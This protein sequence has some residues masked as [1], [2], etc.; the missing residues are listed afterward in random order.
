MTGLALLPLAAVAGPAAAGDTVEVVS[1]HGQSAAHATASTANAAGRNKARTGRHGHAKVFPTQQAAKAQAQAQ[2]PEAA[3]AAAGYG[4]LIYSGGVSGVGVTTGAPQV[5]LVFWGSQWGQSS[6]TST[7]A[8]QLSGDPKGVAPRL[9]ALMKGIGTNNETWSGVMTQ[10]CEGVAPGST[11]CPSTATHVGYPTGGTLAG[12]WADPSAAAPQQ[13]TAQQIA[14]EG[15]RAAGHFGRTTPGSNRNVQY[16]VVSPTGT[17]PDGF[18]TGS[19]TSNFCAWHDWN[20]DTAM[21]GGA[22]ASPY[23]D[24]AFTNLPYVS[25]AGATCGAGYVNGAAGPLDGFL[26]VAGHEYAETIT[27][28]NPAG[29]W[30]DAVGS[31]NA[32]KCS[33]IGVGGSTGAQNLTFATGSFPMQ[34]TWSNTANA[35]EISH[36]VVRTTA[37][38]VV[39][40]T[41]PGTQTGAVRA[42]KTLQL[43]ATDSTGAALSYTAQGLPAGLAISTTGLVSGTPTT[44]GS[45]AVSVTARDSAGGS[46]SASF[47]WTISPASTCRAPGQKLGNTG[48]ETGVA[49]PWRTTAGVVDKSAAQGPH[50]GLWKA[51]LDGY[52]TSHT[53]TL[54]QTVTLPLGCASYTFSYWMHV[55]S[56]DT[57]TLAHDAMTVRAGTTI[58]ATYSNL[59][60]STGYIQRSFGLSRFAGQS[61]TLT[62]TGVENASLQTSFVV[63]D[64]AVTVK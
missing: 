38:P 1:Q 24:I 16:V 35:C 6:T 43:R 7:G 34:A 23:G 2:S 41:N 60:K 44:A 18:N 45:F 64:A 51:W 13:A 47:T 33:W 20:G 54:S 15:V 48:F 3:T 36:A 62:F 37:V 55:S 61:V 40:V 32:D 57:S 52:G 19:A 29:G 22:A 8:L 10:Y 49:A 12:V 59:N 63:D 42:A 46:G 31:E 5:Y 39:T 53:D 30:V 9:Q 28:Q 17:H 27:D 4:G 26:I 14:A 58:L 21:S 25:D 11:A 50:S 56:A